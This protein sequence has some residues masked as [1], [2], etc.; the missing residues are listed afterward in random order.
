MKFIFGLLI[1]LFSQN[2][3]LLNA[4]D[5]TMNYNVKGMMCELNCPGLLKEEASKV[6]GVKK[7]EVDFAKGS[8]IITFDDAKI[9]QKTL[10]ATLSKSTFYDIKVQEENSTQSWW[11]W[12]FGG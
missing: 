1:V 9:D 6:D 3:I 2:S 7:C 11:D 12:L 10:A 4:K 5:V 8:A